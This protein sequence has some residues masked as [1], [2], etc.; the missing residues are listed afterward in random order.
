MKD[1][2]AQATAEAG[3]TR[4]QVEPRMA[5]DRDQRRADISFVEPARM[6]T[7]EIWHYTDD[8]G[9]HPLC[10][11]HFDGPAGRES[12]NPMHTLNVLDQAKANSY[13]FQLDLLRSASA[14]RAGLRV[15]V[16][17]TCSFTSLGQ[18]GPGMVKW[19]NG[20]AGHLKKV[21][22]LRSVPRDDGLLSQNVSGLSRF[23]TRAMHAPGRNLDFGMPSSLVLWGSRCL[24][25]V[26]SYGGALFP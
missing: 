14:V 17:R 16:Y 12:S 11:T 19:L 24:T 8:T 18:L 20:A 1:V 13:A 22:T 21:E 10:R 15:I 25:L 5:P 23:R 6:G 26:F 2:R 7:K 9:G 3:F 4:I